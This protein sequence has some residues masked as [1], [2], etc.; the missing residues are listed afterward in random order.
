LKSITLEA[1]GATKRAVTSI[2]VE[3]VCGLDDFRTEQLEYIRK[4]ARGL[5]VIL[6]DSKKREQQRLATAGR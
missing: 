2:S 6:E 4:I 3:G 1:T 5:K